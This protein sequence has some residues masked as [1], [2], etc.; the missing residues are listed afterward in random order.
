MGYDASTKGA[1]TDLSDSYI[2]FEAMRMTENVED[3]RKQGDRHANLDWEAA[4]EFIERCH[5]HPDFN[6]QPWVTD[7]NDHKGGFAYHPGNTRAGTFQ[8]KEGVVRFRS[9]GSMSYAGL[10]SY[11]YAKIDRHDPRVQ[12]TFK[13]ATE[14]W[15]LDENPGT[16]QEGLFY[17]YNVLAKGLAAFGKDQIWSKGEKPF[18]WRVE[19][20]KKLLSMQKIDPKTGTGYWINET[21]RYWESNPVLVTSYALLAMQYAMGIGQ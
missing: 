8:D 19:I 3:L 6:D 17:Y 18:N 5:N 20:L 15:T 4:V 14:H 1:Y 2:A 7:D 13:W 10:L 21:G 9:F 12:S 11:I 16:G